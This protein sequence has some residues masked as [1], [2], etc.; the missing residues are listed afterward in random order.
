MQRNSRLIV[1]GC[2]DIQNLSGLLDHGTLL[3]GNTLD[4]ALPRHKGVDSHGLREKTLVLARGL[5]HLHSLCGHLRCSVEGATL[6]QAHGDGTHGRGLCAWSSIF[7]ED[8]HRLLGRFQAIF[9]PLHLVSGSRHEEESVSLS[10]TARGSADLAED[11]DSLLAT[12]GSSVLGVSIIPNVDVAL[13]KQHCCL[14]LLVTRLFKECLCFVCLFQGLLDL[15]VP[16]VHPRKKVVHRRLANFAIGRLKL[17]DGLFTQ[18]VCLL[19]LLVIDC[20]LCQ[21]Q[22]GACDSPRVDQ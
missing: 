15:V 11:G 22:Q 7:F 12:F 14:P 16:D 17:L 3:I 5:Q 13:H 2:E 8:L 20:H 9:E 19:R 1:E 18:F 6:H 21:R 10:V 4:D